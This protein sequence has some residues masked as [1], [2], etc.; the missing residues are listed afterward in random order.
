MTLIEYIVKDLKTLAKPELVQVACFVRSLSEVSQKE[1][2][3]ML[4]K[5]FGV[6]S[7]EDGEVFENALA[8]ARKIEPRDFTEEQIA[9]WIAQDEEDMRRFQEGV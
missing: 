7:Q 2:S 3:D 4:K 1:Q 5:T 9:A 6:L 8:G